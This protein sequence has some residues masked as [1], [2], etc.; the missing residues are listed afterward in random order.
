M[1]YDPIWVVDDIVGT[2][3]FQED[4]THRGEELP[5]GTQSPSP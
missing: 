4:G 5:C 1:R 2:A 3:I